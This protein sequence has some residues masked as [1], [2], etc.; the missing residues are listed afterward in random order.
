MEFTYRTVSK[1]F[2]FQFKEK[3]SRF[4]AFLFPIQSELEFKKRMAELKSEFPDAVH[5]C[6]AFRLISETKLER[7]SD[8]GEPSGTAGKPILGQLRS[9]DISN[10]ALVVVRYFGGI[11][12]GTGGLIKAYKTVA[13]QIIE[14][15]NIVPDELKTEVKISCAFEQSGKITGLLKKHRVE[16]LKKKGSDSLEL[17]IRVPICEIKTLENEISRIENSRIIHP[18]Q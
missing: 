6:F 1:E 2:S 10:C 3:G 14:T 11:K 9:A 4:M 8:D 5:H 17:E 7:F 15:A 16:I 18:P 13:K 12:L